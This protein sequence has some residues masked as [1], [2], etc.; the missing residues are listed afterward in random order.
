MG[1]S[2]TRDELFSI[3]EYFNCFSN[4]SSVVKMGAIVYAWLAFHVLTFTNKIT[5]YPYSSVLH[6]QNHR[7]SLLASNI[8]DL[9]KVSF[10]FLNHS[11]TQQVSQQQ[12]CWHLSNLYTT[13]RGHLISLTI[14]KSRSNMTNIWNWFGKPQLWY[15]IPNSSLSSF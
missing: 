15:T 9:A 12:D 7:M 5:C 14:L 4:N 13:L 11:Y 8:C 2:S 1:L 3:S 10:R 6:W